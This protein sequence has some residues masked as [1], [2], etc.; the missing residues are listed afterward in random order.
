MLDIEKII[1]DAIS[2][3]I[4]DSSAYYLLDESIN[5]LGYKKNH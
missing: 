1:R 3:F 4:I 2:I 5:C